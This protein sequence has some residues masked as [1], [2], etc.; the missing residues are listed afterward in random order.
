MNFLGS[1]QVYIIYLKK[2]Q[3]TVGNEMVASTVKRINWDLIWIDANLV[4]AVWICS[5]TISYT[6]LDW[7]IVGTR[8]AATNIPT[9]GCIAV[10]T[11]IALLAIFRRY[12]SH[13]SISVVNTVVYVVAAVVLT[14]IIFL[15]F[16]DFLWSVLSKG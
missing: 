8:E 7:N 4:F 15:V 3:S 9:W 13:R 5:Y 14:T 1:S 10:I 12:S 16:R 6:S 2:P 11:Q